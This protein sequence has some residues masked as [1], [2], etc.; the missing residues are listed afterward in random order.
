MLLWTMFAIGNMSASASDPERK[1]ARFEIDRTSVLRNPAS[2]WVLYAADLNLPD[3]AAYW[4]EVDEFVPTASILYIRLPWSLYEPKKG[5]YAWTQPGNLRNLIEGA[6]KRGLKLA[7]R[8]V[9]N[10]KDCRQSAAP[11]YV[12][13]AGA[14][15]HEE[16]GE[17]GIP[18][19]SPDPT[20]PVFRAEFGKFLDAFAAAFDDPDTVDFIDAIGLGWWGEMH[21]LGFPA[22][23][24]PEVYEWI[25]SAYG[26]RFKRVLLGTQVVS[27]LGNSG[28]LDR[29]IAIEK[30]GYVARLDS[31]GSHWMWHEKL[32]ATIGDTPFFG[33]SCYFSLE[34]WD[35]WKDPKETF[36]NPRQ[37]LEATIKDAFRYR[38]NTLDLRKPND[39]RTWFKLAPDLVQRFVGEGGYRLAPEEIVHPAEIRR[40]AFSIHH[41][42]RNLGVG[43][44]PNAN[45]R[46]AGKYRVAFALFRGSDREPTAVHIDRA[47]D[48]GDW[49]GDQAH[50]CTTGT[51]FAVSPGTY[52]LSVA[53]VDTTKPLRPAIRLAT[54]GP[55]QALS[56]TPVGEIRVKN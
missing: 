8:V 19:W 17:G 21:H 26:S 4:K 45:R 55:S 30:H 42:W 33:E 23:K 29:S 35:M 31:L 27:D 1:A 14:A 6:K 15:G 32:P 38:A 34:S 3:A 48:P 49:T 53:I 46:W 40:D 56:W 20:D 43:V 16:K 54:R 18:L 2:G 13:E 10:S 37:V 41:R 47:T 51:T 44:L 28:P 36:A 50:D 52:R 12:R 7:F 24:R 5:K 39:C 25:C 9:L 22:E 11:G